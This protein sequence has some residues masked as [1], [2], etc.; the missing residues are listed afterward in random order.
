[1]DGNWR[2][3]RRAGRLYELSGSGRLIHTRRLRSLPH[4]RDESLLS[5]LYEILSNGKI[6]WVNSILALF[7]ESRKPQIRAGKR[8]PWGLYRALR[9]YSSYVTRD[10]RPVHRNF[11]SS[12][13][14]T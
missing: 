1:M 13:N 6:R 5:L 10:G 12:L 14:E 4:R 3:F 11:G 9:L 2:K 7:A 8:I